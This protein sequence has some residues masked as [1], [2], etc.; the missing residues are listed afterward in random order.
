[1]RVSILASLI[2]INEVAMTKHDQQILF[3]ALAFL[4]V[5]QKDGENA[6]RNN[7]P[8]VMMLAKLLSEFCADNVLSSISHLLSINDDKDT[9]AKVDTVIERHIKELRQNE[10]TVLPEDRTSL[11]HMYVRL[12]FRKIH[13]INATL[14]S[15]ISIPKLVDFVLSQL[16]EEIEYLEGLS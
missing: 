9:A 14:F 8:K 15:E 7:A 4:A 6:T 1:M 16:D 3:T 5:V 13:R 10:T 12:Q 11:M 2:A